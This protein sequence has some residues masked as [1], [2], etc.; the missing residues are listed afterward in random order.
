MKT[1]ITIAKRNKNKYERKMNIIMQ[2]R[3]NTKIKT[4]IN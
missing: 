1:Q 3:L 4:N 2:I